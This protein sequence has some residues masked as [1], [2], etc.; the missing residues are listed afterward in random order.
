M[1]D[2]V[3]DLFGV[4]PYTVLQIPKQVRCVS[5]PQ[6]NLSGIERWGGGRETESGMLGAQN[7]QK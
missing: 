7:A 2:Y 4:R 6:I 5:W 3:G 1:T